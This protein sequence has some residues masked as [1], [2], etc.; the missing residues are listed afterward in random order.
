MS[1]RQLK[2]E[3]LTLL[4]E[5]DLDEILKKLEI[6]PNQRLLNPLFAALCH[7]EER[8][9][10]N[11]ISCFGSVVPAIADDDPESARIVMRRFLWSLNDES[12]GIGWGSPEAMA[13][14]M[15]QSD[16]LREEYLHMLIS[17]MREDGEEEFQDGNYLELPMLQRGLLWG[18][19]RLCQSH[20]DEMFRR[21]VSADIA[22]Y[23][24][25]PDELVSGLSIWCLG[26][27]GVETA[28]E[29]ISSFLHSSIDLHI[30][31]EG[32]IQT[33]SVAQ[34]SRKVLDL[35]DTTAGAGRCLNT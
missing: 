34:L 31:I 33:I 25:S 29:K 3:V 22:A 23:L 19:G 17:Y 13:E 4:Q 16:R 28:R 12:G 32:N 1:R 7:P 8:V 5:T 24:D 11:A 9:R 20:R 2:L 30:F 27:L 6:Y 14:I 35:G 15:C 26:L 21:Q 10:W 18:V